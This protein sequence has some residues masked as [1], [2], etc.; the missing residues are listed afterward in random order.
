MF[1]LSFDIPPSEKKIGLDA[2]IFLQGSC[3]S[4]EIGT[5]LLANKLDVLSNPFGTIFNPVSLLQVLTSVPKPD[6][7]VE[8][9][10]VYYHWDAH[11][12]IAGRT[13]QEV[14]ER[15]EKTFEEQRAFLSECKWLILTLGS[16][17]VYEWSDGSL[18]ANCHKRPAKEF[19]KRFLSSAEII[20]A[21][22]QAKDA[23]RELNPHVQFILTVSPVRHLR[24]GLIANNRSKSILIEATHALASAHED[25]AYFPSYEIV[26]DELRDYRFFKP[27]F[28]HPSEQAV[29]YVWERFQQTYFTAEDRETINQ[30]SKL[31]K[32][33]EHR[34]FYP[35]TAAHK[36]F[37][38]STLEKL[39]VLNQSLDVTAEIR[40]IREQLQ[41]FKK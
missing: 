20:A 40:K 26:M 32:A 12:K 7:I 5:R 3:F 25:I 21:F 8:S 4:D 35:Q 18:V 41:Q 23:I 29:D 38:E 22:E 16:A 30:W 9:Q 15:L 11:G 27:D 17:L 24:D 33:L 13:A 34:P 28:A 39:E 2:S 10:G 1:Q 14:Q 37:L 19:K 36:G 6:R 31:R